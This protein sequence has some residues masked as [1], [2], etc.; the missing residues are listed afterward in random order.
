MPS[1][2]LWCCR[3]TSLSREE[4]QM[5]V[6]VVQLISGFCA[7]GEESDAFTE[8]EAMYGCRRQS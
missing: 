1:D 4:A 5:L 3:G 2:V 7:T 8:A 6:Q